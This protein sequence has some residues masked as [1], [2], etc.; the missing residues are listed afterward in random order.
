MSYSRNI[1]L[2]LACLA[3][4]GSQPGCSPEISQAAAAGK[5]RAVPVVEVAAV[6]L[7][8][9]NRP[10]KVS[11]LVRSRQAQ[12]LGFKVGGVLG[13]VLVE[14]GQTVK[15]GQVL[16]TIDPVEYSAS[17]A[18]ARDGLQKADRDLARA[19]ALA[20]EGAVPKA[21]LDD[22]QTAARVARAS[23]QMAGFNE[24]HTLLLAPTAGVVEQRLVEPGEVVAP[25]RPVVAFLGLERGWAV[26]VA[27]SDREVAA[28]H[29]G[30]AA[31]VVFDALPGRTV[32]ARLGDIARLANPATGTFTAEVVLPE[33]LP[34]TA[35]SGLVARVEFARLEAAKSIVPLAALVDGEGKR[36]AVFTIEDGQAKR[37]PVEVMSLS[38][39]LAGLVTEL[40]AN[41]PV[42]IRGAAEL[43]EG[44]AVTVSTP[45]GAE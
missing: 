34:L 9:L 23:A 8:P 33:D 7:G 4:V 17:A 10:L 21:T 28:L 37:H 12:S 14:P 44:S 11:G 20:K 42:V 35:R 15:K 18:Q 24:R 6:Q 5:E 36:A 22:A 40:P 31:R 2:A 27:L 29:S 26:D 25:G 32:E 41:Q 13:N 39:G 3:M 45:N 43:M 16:A 38:D 19:T 30:Q 1:V